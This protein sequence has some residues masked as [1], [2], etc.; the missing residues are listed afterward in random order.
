MNLKSSTSSSTLGQ[1]L[2]GWGDPLL[3]HL[4]PDLAPVQ[5]HVRLGWDGEPLLHFLFLVHNHNISRVT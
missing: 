2:C 3:L 4:Q 5:R 1:V